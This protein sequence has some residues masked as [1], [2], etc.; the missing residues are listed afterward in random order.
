MHLFNFIK[1]YYK[2]R[3]TCK[4]LKTGPH[5]T[6]PMGFAK[7]IFYSKRHHSYLSFCNKYT[8]HT[9][10]SRT[11]KECFKKFIL[12]SSRSLFISPPTQNFLKYFIYSRVGWLGWWCPFLGFFFS[13]NR[14]FFLNTPQ[15]KLNRHVLGDL[16]QR[17]LKKFS[18]FFFYNSNFFTFPFPIYICF[19]Y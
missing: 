8:R 18:K 14:H 5:L 3:V 19:I 4:S 15:I 9:P 10:K 13:Y 12:N 2:V 7:I 1:N 6:L 17:F 16:I 11:E